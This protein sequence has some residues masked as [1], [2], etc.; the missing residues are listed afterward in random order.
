[1]MTRNR[2]LGKNR[3]TTRQFEL[4]IRYYVSSSTGEEDL[5]GLA[6]VKLTT[7]A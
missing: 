4:A 2:F 7:I 5:V 6:P 3:T 1:M